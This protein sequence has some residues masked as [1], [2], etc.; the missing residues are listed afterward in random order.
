MKVPPLDMSRVN[1]G[2][3]GEVQAQEEDE[4]EEE[5]D[6]EGEDYDEEDEEVA[7]DDVGEVISNIQPIDSSNAYQYYPE[8]ENIDLLEPSLQ[9]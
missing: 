1:M 2:Q 8:D 3:G 5:Y 6:M 4:E 7:A 9:P